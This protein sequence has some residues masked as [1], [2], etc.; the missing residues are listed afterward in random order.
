M[1]LEA[2]HLLSERK[3][4]LFILCG[5]GAVR[6][7][8]VER[9]KGLPN[10]RFID[11]VP[12]ARLNDL[13]NM[14]D[15]HLLPQRADIEDLVMPSKLHGIFASG[16]PVVATA[17]EGTQIA[18]AVTGRG[19]VVRPGDAGAFTEAV[20]MLSD[21]HDLRKTLGEGARDYCLENWGMLKVLKRLEEK[22]KDVAR[23]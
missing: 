23:A 6:T 15:I 22:M 4:L 3:D 5:D 9:S 17:H 18:R 8:L 7:R 12:M 13:L 20:S 1:I 11:L 16:R 10:V 2:A 14:A 19:V 21:D